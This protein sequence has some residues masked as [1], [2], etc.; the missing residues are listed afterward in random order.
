ML[1]FFGNNNIREYK[2][3]KGQEDHSLGY[4]CANGRHLNIQGRI[5][6]SRDCGCHTNH[7]IPIEK[8]YYIP[9][10]PYV[11]TLF[12]YNIEHIAQSF[13]Q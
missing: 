1:F 10:V 13:L 7:F 6:K 5:K 11:S 2:S 4:S 12:M 9:V 8:N 3:D